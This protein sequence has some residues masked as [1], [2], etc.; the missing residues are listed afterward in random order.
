MAID[1]NTLLQEAS[2]FS[3]YSEASTA[4]LLELALLNRIAEG[5][6]GGTPGGTDTQ[7]QFNDGGVFGGDA[8]FTWNKTTN[9]LSITGGETITAEANET[10]FTISGYSL[11]G[12]N[13]QSLMSLAGTWNT[14]GNATAIRLAITDTASGATSKMVEILGGAA[15][16]TSLMSLSK[17]GAVVLPSTGS[18]TVT[19]G[20]VLDA[21]IVV[22]N[23]MYWSTRSVMSSPVNGNIRFTNNAQTDFGLLQLGGTAATFPAIKRSSTLI[24]AR[25]ADDSAYCDFESRILRTATAFTVATLPAA[26]T[27]GRI[28]YVTDALAPAFLTAVVGGGAVVTPVFDNGAAWVAA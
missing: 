24:Q 1:A 26:G 13:A 28:A 2:C 16:A 11:T 19:S 4:Q 15:G 6:G 8:A 23:L 25:L 9:L 7:V 3:C 27:A 12:A 17:T 5:G 22:S 14:S 20:S 18:L 10:P 21:S